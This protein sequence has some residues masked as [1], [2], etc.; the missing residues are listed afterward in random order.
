MKC[1]TFCLTV[2]HSYSNITNK[3]KAT[4][5]LIVS[6][7]VGHAFKSLELIFTVFVNDLVIKFLFSMLMVLFFV[8][9][10]PLEGLLHWPYKEVS[11]YSS[12]TCFGEN[13]ILHESVTEIVNYVQHCEVKF[14]LPFGLKQDEIFSN[15]FIR[16]RSLENFSQ[17]SPNRIHYVYQP[18]QSNVGPHIVYMIQTAD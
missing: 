13:A 18:S 14:G 5:K 2:I 4:C 8:S 15:F 9:E 10:T 1:F 16:A 6:E 12:V 7:Q 17:G 3:I 11:L